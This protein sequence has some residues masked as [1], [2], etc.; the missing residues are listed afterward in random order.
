[1]NDKKGKHDWASAP[2]GLA[3]DLMHGFLR[4]RFGDRVEIFPELDTGAG[5]VDLYMKFEG[6]LSI[7]VELK[8]SGG[9]YSSPYAAAGEKQIHHYMDNRKTHLGY[10]VVVDGRIERFGEKLLSLIHPTH[11]VVEKLIDVRPVVKTS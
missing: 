4:A 1:V 8:M 5:R 9:R 7:V 11:T 10:L 2:E 6:G 3:Q